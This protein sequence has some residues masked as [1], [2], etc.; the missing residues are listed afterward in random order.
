MSEQ[1]GTVVVGHCDC[2]CARAAAKA[3]EERARRDF[4]DMEQKWA[5]AVAFGAVI[6]AERDKLA[7]QLE[8]L[9]KDYETVCNDIRN[10]CAYIKGDR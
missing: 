7:A 9:T 6:E 3:A 2:R 10:L 5:T 8:W 1:E 4:A